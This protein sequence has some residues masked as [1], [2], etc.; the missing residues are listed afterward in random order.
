MNRET[1]CGRIED[2]L[3]PGRDLTEAERRDVGD[4]LRTC[5]GCRDWARLR[6]TLQPF[7][8]ATAED[9]PDIL[10]ASVWPQVEARLAAPGAGGAQAAPRRRRTVF[11]AGD[12]LRRSWWAAPR[13]VPALAAAVVVL[14]VGAGILAGRVRTLERHERALTAA[15]ERRTELIDDL[16]RQVAADMG[17]GSTIE[18]A[19]LATGGETTAGDLLRQLE[20]LPPGRDLLTP[21]QA[22]LLM[23]RAAAA[24]NEDP[25]RL[26]RIEIADGLQAGEAVQLLAAFS[27]DPD[28]K[29]SRTRLHAMSRGLG[30]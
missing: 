26:P 25:G 19:A 12:P 7:V 8:E 2:L 27:L 28:Q 18:L 14:V 1:E 22:G 4:H 24:L 29:I 3:S 21:G 6:D 11:P 10:A 23:R 9:V 13:L 16:R 17:A 15:L 20:A 5:E 30:L